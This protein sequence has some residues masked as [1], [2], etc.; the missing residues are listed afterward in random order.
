MRGRRETGGDFSTQYDELW[1]EPGAAYVDQEH[2]AGGRAAPLSRTAGI[3][4]PDA[5]YALGL[6]DVRVSIDDGVGARKTSRQADL[7]PG[8]RAR[9]VQHPDPHLLDFEEAALGQKAAQLRLVGVAV[10]GGHRRPERL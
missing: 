1:L 5:A 9:R 8:P 7:A 6:R 2:R 10:D 3:E 4:E